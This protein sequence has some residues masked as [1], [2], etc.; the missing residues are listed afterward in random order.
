M[1]SQFKS[2]MVSID[3]RK[4]MTNPKVMSVADDGTSFR[5]LLQALLISGEVIY[6]IPP[7]PRIFRPCETDVSTTRGSFTTGGVIYYHL[8]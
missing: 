6:N 3:G 4:M 7:N 5:T 1:A 2:V 8:P